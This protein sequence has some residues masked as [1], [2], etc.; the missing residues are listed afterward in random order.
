MKAV[1]IPP[2][3]ATVSVSII[4]TGSWVYNIPYKNFF[5]PLLDG[6]DTFDL[7]S[8]AFLV[9]HHGTDGERRVL[10]DLG[11]RKDWENLVPATVQTIKNWGCDMEMGKDVADILVEHGE[12]LSDIE[13][14]VWSHLHWDHIG[15]PSKFPNSVKVLVGPGVT[16]AHMPGWP[17]IGTA[18][19]KEDDIKNHEV[20]EISEDQFESEI[21]GMPAYDYFG[22]GSFYLLSAVGHS[23]GHLNALARTSIE[24]ESYILMAADSVHLGGEFRPSRALPLPEVADEPG[25]SPWPCPKDILLEL[26]PK[27]SATSPFFGLDPCFPFDFRKAKKTIERIQAFDAD[28]RVLVIFAHDVEIYNTLEYYPNLAN[29]WYLQGWKLASRWKFL[30]DIQMAMK[31]HRARSTSGV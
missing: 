27:R 17:E 6:L 29:D 22:D 5:S 18:E 3:R 9:T 12:K 24:H 19:F 11:M 26:H 31:R 10:F 14:I 15:N 1:Y 23:I 28:D 20:V 13:A 8:Y 7:C 4:D 16:E 25:L 21:G 30:V 2:S